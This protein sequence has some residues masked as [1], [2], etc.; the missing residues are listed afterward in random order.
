[1]SRTLSLIGLSL[2]LCAGN[3]R[4]AGDVEESLVTARFPNRGIAAM[5][6]RLVESGPYKR[7]ILLMPGHPG[8]MKLES[9]TSFQLNGNFLIRSRKTWP[10]RET[11][12]FSV[13][14]PS[15]EWGSFTGSLFEQSSNSPGL[16]WFDF[17]DLKL[18]MLWVH[19]EGGPCRYTPY[20]QAKRHDE[21]TRSPLIA[22]RSASVGRG[23][24]CQA[25]S[26][27]GFVGAEEATVR[28]MRHW[29]VEGVAADMVVAGTGD[30]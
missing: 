10:D 5:A 6:T 16:A 20:W 8:I 19:H 9:P 27:H 22:V 7:A 18:P 14:A 21:K 23:D 30:Q 13:D 24:P 11:I 12:V 29:V 1:M 26:P 3:L 28:A 4:A 15:D 2:L 17:D 25:F